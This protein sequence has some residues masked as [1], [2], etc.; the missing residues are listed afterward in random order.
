[1]EKSSNASAEFQKYVNSVIKNQETVFDISELPF[2]SEIS[3][4]ELANAVVKIKNIESLNLSNYSLRG[5]WSVGANPIVDRNITDSFINS[6]PNL[7]S[8]IL[9]NCE[10]NTLAIDHFLTKLK[11]LSLRNNPA[12]SFIY[13][14]PNVPLEYLD[15]SLDAPIN[16]TSEMPPKV[17]IEVDPDNFPKTL[18]TLVCSNNPSFTAF[19]IR[20]RQGNTFRLNQGNTF[21]KLNT[22]YANGA[23]ILGNELSLLFSEELT[24][25]KNLY[26][27]NNEIQN[28]TPLQNVVN[29]EILNL[30]GNKIQDITYIDLNKNLSSLNLVDNKIENILSLSDLKELQDLRL[31]NNVL[32]DISPLEKGA[33]LSVLHLNNCQLKS[34]QLSAIANLTQLTELKLR[35]NVLEN[36][37]FVSKLTKLQVLELSNNQ[38]ADITPLET[39]YRNISPT[40]TIELIDLQNNKI[41]EIEPFAAFERLS[42]LYLQGNPVKDYPLDRLATVTVPKLKTFFSEPK[43]ELNSQAK[44]ILFGNSHVGKTT[45]KRV[46]EGEA[47]KKKEN[48]TPGVQISQWKTKS[49]YNNE[50]SVNIWDFGG[51]EYYHGTHRLFLTPNSIFVLLWNRKTNSFGKDAENLYVDGIAEKQELDHFHYDYWLDNID[52]YSRKLQ[53][54]EGSLSDNIFLIQ[55]LFPN[56]GI[57]KLNIPDE[58][59]GIKATFAFNL[60]QSKSRKRLERKEKLRFDTFEEELINLLSEN[61]AAEKMTVNEAKI[62]KYF[63]ELFEAQLSR[64]AAAADNPLGFVL[65][66]NKQYLEWDE[67]FTA[68]Q[69]VWDTLT[70]KRLHRFLNFLQTKGVVT[71]IRHFKNDMYQDR[72]IFFNQ[73]W[74]LDTIN[75]ILGKNAYSGKG[76]FSR[77][78]VIKVKEVGLELADDF[79]ELMERY[80]IAVK[81]TD[82]TSPHANHQYLAPQ[83]LPTTNTLDVFFKFAI[84]H[85]QSDILTIRLPVFYYRNAMLRLIW[86]YGSNLTQEQRAMLWKDGI[87]FT[88]PVTEANVFVHGKNFTDNNECDIT[89]AVANKTHKETLEIQLLEDILGTFNP[90]YRLY[91]RQPSEKGK[92]YINQKDYKEEDFKDIRGAFLSKRVKLSVKNSG[93]VSIE[94]ILKQVAA[95][96]SFVFTDKGERLPM[97]I[98]DSF[99]SI[100]VLKLKQPQP[101]VFISYSHNKQDVK[102]KN[103]LT[104]HLAIL[105]KNKKIIIYTDEKI[106][107]GKQWD[108]EIYENLMKSEVFIMLISSDYFASDYI[109]E[110]E[111][112]NIFQRLESNNVKI[113]PVLLRRCLI[114]QEVND[115]QFAA[116]DYLGKRTPLVQWTYRDDAWLEVAN[117]VKAFL[118]L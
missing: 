73:K 105:E 113:I 34:N 90:D 108:T 74:L 78:D 2:A 9:D 94:D 98:Y 61:A 85:S 4:S 87:F 3:I 56:D 38:I 95:D 92:V 20:L 117:S 110:K 18:Q 69:S 17:L 88:D 6:L 50:L 77:Q 31:S 102:M 63:V 1:M 13:I 103:E 101:S 12:F 29:L 26:L 79:I 53:N 109:M 111:W 57:Y 80:N 8:L 75:D 116:R 7:K 44:L 89:I 96:M 45:L 81:I 84:S 72:K 10:L 52:F 33:Q 100:K 62:Q 83:Y 107:S 86:L 59:T 28:I 15:L 5:M 55:N 14:H 42:F 118:S 68:C 32:T 60:W 41:R 21:E 37:N 39:Y 16:P 25:L 46:L 99:I 23:G 76:Y 47:I 30:A 43:D 65:Q 40:A 24:N 27:Q 71:Y 82:D 97:K 36:I 67:L 49:I 115:L 22:L 35:D 70:E 19:F 66:N 93:F 48:T 58:K 51:Q 91:V 54:T 114:P 106:E 104:K 64:Q 11:T 112:A